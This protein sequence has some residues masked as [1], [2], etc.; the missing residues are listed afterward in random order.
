[1]AKILKKRRIF[2]IFVEY[3]SYREIEVGMVGEI[4]G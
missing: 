1:M 4:L 3:I 2:K